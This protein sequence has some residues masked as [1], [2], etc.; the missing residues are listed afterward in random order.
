MSDVA[1]YWC[2]V[3]HDWKG[4]EIKDRKWHVV[5]GN[6]YQ[7][8][9][10]MR[11]ESIPTYTFQEVLDKLPKRIELKWLYIVNNEN[12]ILYAEDYY[13]DDSDALSC[14]ELRY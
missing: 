9:G 12:K 6:S 1:L 3:S 11:Y 5:V 14:F 4:K 7:S 2:S 8:V 10:M 13:E